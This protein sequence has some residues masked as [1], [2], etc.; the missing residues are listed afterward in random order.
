[1]ASN[2]NGNLTG[3]SQYFNDYRV[4]NGVATTS[5][6]FEPTGFLELTRTSSPADTNNK[7]KTLSMWVKRATLSTSQTLFSVS[8]GSNEYYS[9]YFDTNNKLNFLASQSRANVI[10][11]NV[12]R[13][14]SAWYHIVCAWD[15]SQGTESNRVKIYVNGVQETSFSTANYP[16]QNSTLQFISTSASNGHVVG[17]YYNGSAYSGGFDGL[18]SHIHFRDGHSL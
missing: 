18:M 3:S 6:R 13:D 1:V 15:T 14:V 11:T 7:I 12:F 17:A 16:S 8:D 10:S 9:L 5:L 2:G 4:Y